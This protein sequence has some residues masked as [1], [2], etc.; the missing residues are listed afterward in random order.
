MT[1]SVRCSGRHYSHSCLQA[2]VK[3]IDDDGRLPE[4][5]GCSA[6]FGAPS[7]SAEGK[8]KLVRSSTQALL[9]SCHKMSAQMRDGNGGPQPPGCLGHRLPAQT[10]R[11]G[12]LG[13]G[14]GGNG[15][16]GTAVGD[17]LLV[18]NPKSVQQWLTTGWGK[19]MEGVWPAYRRQN[20]RTGVTFSATWGGRFSPSRRGGLSLH[21]ARP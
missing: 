1:G 8:G 17:Q 14:E 9:V 16:L 10:Q 2:T 7:K 11:R 21:R 3:P 13:P 18:A 4:A 20:G 19:V 5:D 12:K 15:E 6:P